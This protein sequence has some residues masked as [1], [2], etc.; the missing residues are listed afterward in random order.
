MTP[1]KDLQSV[2]QRINLATV[3][4]RNNKTKQQEIVILKKELSAE[5]RKN[6]KGIEALHPGKSL[7]VRAAIGDDYAKTL[8]RKRATKGQLWI[9]KTLLADIPDLYDHSELTLY[10]LNSKNKA[11]FESIQLDLRTPL[12][13]TI[14]AEGIDS[15]EDMPFYKTRNSKSKNRDIDDDDDDDQISSAE[16]ANERTGCMSC[17]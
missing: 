1:L 6:K 10:F 5:R 9:L 16:S 13:D 15:V 12:P 3:A 8:Q 4:R 17:R 7:A 2:I 14:D 11:V